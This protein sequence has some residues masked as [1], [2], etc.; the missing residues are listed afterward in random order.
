MLFADEALHV[1]GRR[2]IFLFFLSKKRDNA[3]YIYIYT[4]NVSNVYCKYD[5]RV[6]MWL[7]SF[8]ATMIVCMD[9]YKQII[10]NTMW[11]LIEK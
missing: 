3:L 4:T 6:C 1:C 5:A 7:Y 11:N 9:V 8:D 2:L 10:K